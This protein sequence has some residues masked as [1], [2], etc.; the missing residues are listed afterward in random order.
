M[1][2]FIILVL[3]L[4]SLRAFAMNADCAAWLNSTT[5]A[6]TSA[7]FGADGTIEPKEGYKIDVN[8]LK[9]FSTSLKQSGVTGG[10][11]MLGTLNVV[12]EGKNIKS[13][14]NGFKNGTS[15]TIYLNDSGENCFPKSQYSLEVVNGKNVTYLDWDTEMCGKIQ[16]YF[17]SHPELKECD[18]SARLSE[19]KGIL[20]QYKPKKAGELRF[21]SVTGASRTDFNPMSAAKAYSHVCERIVNSKFGMK[22]MGARKEPKRGAIA[23]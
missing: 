6:G 23:Q 5:S 10:L 15:E 7:T 3:T 17:D 11:F 1:R 22:N 12:R 14:T 4:T 18:N 16:E 20:D 2:L 8:N 9:T 19:L 13:I 21:A